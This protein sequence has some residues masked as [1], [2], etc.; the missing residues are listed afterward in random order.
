MDTD[1]LQPVVKT[2]RQ[3]GEKKMDRKKA[4]E[5]GWVITGRGDNVKG[6]KGIMI[7]LGRLNLVLKMIEKVTKPA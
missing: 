1:I 2:Q 7:F 5:L 4:E 6:E 3:L